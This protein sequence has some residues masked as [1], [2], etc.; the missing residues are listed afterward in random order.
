MKILEN[1]QAKAESASHSAAVSLNAARDA[2]TL[3]EAERK[4]DDEQLLQEAARQYRAKH[5]CSATEAFVQIGKRAEYLK[6]L[7]AGESTFLEA[8][9]QLEA[10]ANPSLKPA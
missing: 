7:A 3:L 5:D 2:Y 8:K 4:G 9:K 6:E 10:N 1:L